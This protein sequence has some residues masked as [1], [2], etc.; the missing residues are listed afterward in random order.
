[1]KSRAFLEAQV[2]PTERALVEAAAN[3]W[4]IENIGSSWP[5]TE[6]WTELVEESTEDMLREELAD[7]TVH[8]VQCAKY[9]LDHSLPLTLK[10][11]EVA[12][13]ELPLVPL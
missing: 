10:S 1:V 12:F 9:V 6:H 3:R 2:H 7:W 4:T 8:A 11:M 13:N 5:A